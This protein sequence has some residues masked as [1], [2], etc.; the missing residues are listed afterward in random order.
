MD[1]VKCISCGKEFDERKEKKQV[2]VTLSN[3]GDVFCEGKVSTCPH[4]QEDYVEGEDIFE[5]AESF[6]KAHMKKYCEFKKIQV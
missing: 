3:P 6:D 4:C 5:L 2:K 1:K